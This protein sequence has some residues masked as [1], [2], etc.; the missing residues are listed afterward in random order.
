MTTIELTGRI[1]EDGEL[2]AKVPNHI[3]PGEV[4]IIVQLPD[5]IVQ[6]DTSSWTEDELDDLLKIEV[7]TNQEIFAMLNSDEYTS[8]LEQSSWRNVTN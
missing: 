8:E 7:A 1:T 4:H 5:N 2:R 6:G 3:K